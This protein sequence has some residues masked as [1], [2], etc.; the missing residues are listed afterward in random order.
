M[1]D[2]PKNLP[3]HVTFATGAAL[4]RQLGIDE[5]AT[6]DSLRH[7]ARSRPSWPFGEGDGKVPYVPAGNARAMATDVLLDYLDKEPPNPRGRGR[8]KK[9]RA[10]PGEP[11]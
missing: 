6:A 2:R 8:D 5:D 4:L 1:S 9:P 7:L 11:R 3:S 10:R